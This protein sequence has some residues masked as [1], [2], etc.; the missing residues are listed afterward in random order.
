MISYDEKNR[1]IKLDTA[2]TSYVITIT[3]E[4]G[5]VGHAYYGKR[6]SDT[7]AYLNR[8]GENP[9]VP[10]K[11]NR[12]RCSFLDTFPT[13][14]AGNCVGDYREGAVAIRDK[15][16]RE[17]VQFLYDSHE[18]LEEKPVLPGLPS[19]FAGEGY[20][21]QTLVIHMKDE[22]ISMEADLYYS[23]FEDI[24]VITR[25]VKLKN[26][27]A[28]PVA[29][30]K[31]MSLCL[32][33][34]A[35]DLEL[36]T[37]HGSW[38][39]ER[40][41]DVRP[42][43]FGRTNMESAR[44][45]TSHQEHPFLALLSKGADQ[46]K[47]DVFAFNF[48]YSGNFRAQ[49]EKSQFDSLRVTMGISPRYFE[50][51]LKG[52][53]EFYAPEAVMTY[54]SAGL[55]QM[56]RNFHD[57]FRQH[58]IRS[59]YKSK[60]RP[61]LINNWEATYF[62]F[63][64]EK[65]L[66]IAREAKKCGVEMLVMDDG[67]FGHRDS[68]NSSLGDWFVYEDKLKGGLAHLVDEV[69]KIGLKFGI[70]LEPEMISEDS[71]AFKAHPDYRIQIAGREPAPSR[72]QFVLDLS[73]P[74][75]VDFVYDQIKAVLSSANI[76]Y[77]KW[78]MNRQLSDLGSI[79]LGKENQGELSH[80]YVLAVY[81]LQER[82]MRD[83]PNL[84]LENCSGGGAR[85][86]GGMLYYSPQIWCS[87]D[88]DA[89]ER[90]SIQ[91]GTAL[92]YPVSTMGAHVSDCPNHECGRVT[93]FDTRGDVALCGTFGYELDVTKISK[94]D[95]DKMPAQIEK[96]HKYNP[97]IREGDYYRL[98]SYRENKLFDSY[99]IVA[100]DKSEALL[101]YVQVLGRPNRHSRRLKLAGLDP[102]KKYRVEFEGKDESL[103]LYGDTLMNAGILMENMWGDFNSR[104]VYLRAV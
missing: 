6:I 54:S 59:P 68:D 101:C 80:R 57:L 2:N 100:K 82:M 72:E 98:A 89:I 20:K 69:N 77:V 18:I 15:D 27:G 32:D 74:E 48:I 90:L 50:Y 91:E 19:T 40:E 41:I 8:T 85:F 28:D 29:V 16:G 25:S 36:L 21:V 78:D 14:F 83:F 86:D 5:F 31:I 37:L 11:N 60:S 53:E 12:D 62:K 4:E 39:R 42:I 97:L 43:G 73:R 26:A 92:V 71:E 56:T 23:V 103:E 49:V 58:L 34:E 3:D 102:D 95:R 52:G 66:D 81:E 17:G 65:L 33:M 87:D 7:A 75:V 55:G 99:M 94:E 9:F 84:L 30:T 51:V 45:E 38:C 24:D 1:V 35:D 88:T 46:N 47:G 22:C 96:Y 44:G 63:D 79:Y 13:E 10:S 67:W 93:P 104:L 64:T 70:W 76:E 61:V